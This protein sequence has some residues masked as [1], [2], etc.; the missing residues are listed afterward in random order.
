MLIHDHE[1][2]RR[3][4]LR[5]AGARDGKVYIGPEVV[6]LLIT[7]QCNLQ[8]RECLFHAPVAPVKPITVKTLAVDKLR[9]IIRD[10]VALKV[11]WIELYGEG[12]PTL[13]PGFSA[14]MDCFKDQPIGVRLL[15]NGVFGAARIGDVL[16]ADKVQINCSAI[17]R[18]TYQ[19]FHGRDLF[20]RVMDN[21]REL[22]LRRN[23][24][25]LPCLI[26]V[27]YLLREES[28]VLMDEVRHFFQGLGVDKVVFR[29][30]VQDGLEIA[31]K[32]GADAPDCFYG[33]FGAIAD[34]TVRPCYCL[35]GDGKFD[36]KQRSFKEIWLSDDF[37]NVRMDGRHGRLGG[38]VA[39]GCRQCR[40][41]SEN[42]LFTHRLRRLEDV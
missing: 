13:H 14:L 12:E 29:T 18:D 42:Q 15:T 8:C 11:N 39:G 25:K 28:A 35:P 4:V 31:D 19:A 37:M 41:Y 5:L 22:T 9:E 1:Q 17:A 20:D 10:C 30:F 26:T 32:R 33:W 7:D 36:L 21:V 27:I 24:R 3:T 34:G 40:Y 2:Q 6:H 38:R 23:A 16:R